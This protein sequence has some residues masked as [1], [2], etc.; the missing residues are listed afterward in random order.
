MASYRVEITEPAEDDLRTIVRYISAQ[1]SA[2][3]TALRMMGIIEKSLGNLGEMPQR[4]PFV[5]DDRLATLGYRTLIIEHYA[6]FFSID[7]IAKV[8]YVERILYARRDWA[9]L[10]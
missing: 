7:E 9:S 1:L 10:L 4:C 6:A 8:V 3:V 2:P 5:R